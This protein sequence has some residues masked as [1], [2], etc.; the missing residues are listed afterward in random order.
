MVMIMQEFGFVNLSQ[1]AVPNDMENARAYL[2][3]R[4]GEGY[5]PRLLTS[6][7]IGAI[8]YRA[9]Q[10]IKRRPASLSAA[11][12]LRS[13]M[14]LPETAATNMLKSL[15]ERGLIVRAEQH[16]G[17]DVAEDLRAGVF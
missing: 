15:G 16:G 1:M 9:L 12:A 8:D 6:H 13:D 17:W 11:R 10:A 5:M 4:T 3:T 14:A 2:A 7:Q